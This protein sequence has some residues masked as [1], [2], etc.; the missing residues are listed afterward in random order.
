MPNQLFNY[1]RI[2]EGVFLTVSEQNALKQ[3]AF[4]IYEHGNT[5]TPIEV[6]KLSDVKEY[7]E[8]NLK[9]DECCSECDII[10]KFIKT[11]LLEGF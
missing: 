4:T 9:D 6:V 8:E 5:V 10:N 3:K 1:K 7:L 2:T 11:V